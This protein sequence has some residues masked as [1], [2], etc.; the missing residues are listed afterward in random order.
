M[1]GRPRKPNHV[2]EAQG[3]LQ[4]CRVN[5][6]PLTF[7]PLS[8]V[9]MPVRELDAEGLRFFRIVCELM[10]SKRLL[11]PA[12]LLDITQAAKNYSYLIKIEKAL[13]EDD[14]FQVSESGWKQTHTGM[15]AY[16]DLQKSLNEFYNRYGLNLTASQKIEMPESNEKEPEY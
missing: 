9:P 8:A 11:T 6:H 1:A 12:F 2:K 16:S 4:K 14:L 7:E 5:D 15:K 3:T 10:I 13:D